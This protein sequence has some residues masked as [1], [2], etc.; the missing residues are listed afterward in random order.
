MNSK[1]ED[2]LDEFKTF[3][4]SKGMDTLLSPLAFALLNM[5]FELQVAV[6]GA[7]LIALILGFR[8][9]VKK[10]NIAYALG[11]LL[12]VS[13]ASGLAYF[14]NNAVNYFLPKLLTSGVLLVVTL[15]S[16]IIRK[17]IT[18][19]ASHLMRHWPIDWYLR[20]DIYPAYREVAWIWLILI[21]TRFSIIGLLIL[22]ENLVQLSIMNLLL[23]TPFTISILILSY[24]Y[25]I[26]R[27]KT[28]KGPSVQEYLDNKLPPWQGQA[29]G[30]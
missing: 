5:L 19:W 30:F 16:L 7:V 10:E 14:S 26:W 13:F 6:I 21:F 22:K 25:G 15:L 24:V 2:I 29:K 20:K 28:L 1:I 17:P 12:G 9:L 27:L 4:T 23:G 18:I 3:Y 11:G 8:R